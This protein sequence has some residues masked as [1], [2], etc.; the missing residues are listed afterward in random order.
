MV[1]APELSVLCEGVLR[2][3]CVRVCDRD[4]L[5]VAGL[6]SADCAHDFGRYARLYD[7]EVRFQLFFVFVVPGG[8]LEMRRRHVDKEAIPLALSEWA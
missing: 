7:R 2:A 4:K 1:D 3:L 6:A 5:A 8:S